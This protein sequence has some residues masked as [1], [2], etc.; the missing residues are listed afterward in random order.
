M[1]GTIRKHSKWLWVIIAALTIA[2]FVWWG[3]N[4]ASRYGSGGSGGYGTL[5]GKPITP[6]QFAAAERE[7][8][9][10]YWMRSGQ[11]P[12]PPT[13]TQL[14]IDQN[15]YQRLL[16]EAKAAELGVH[17]TDEA[18]AAE[19][20]NFLASL[21]KQSQPIAMSTFVERV[22]QPKGLTGDDFKRTLVGNLAIQ[23]LVQSIGLAGSLVPPQEVAQL[24]DHDHQEFSAQAIFF[25]ATNY[26]A[27]VAATPAAVGTFYTNHMAEY[28][29]ADRVLL[30]YVA[31]DLTNYLAATEQKLGKTNV[32]AVVEATFAQRGLEGVPDAKTPEE[33]KAKIHDAYLRQEA[34]KTAVEEARQFAKTL[35]SIE[36]ASANTLLLLAQTNGLKGQITAPFSEAEGPEEF[37]AP[38]EL[39]KTAFKLSPESPFGPRPIQGA[40]SVYV[41]ALAKQL[42][43]EVLPFGEIHDR[44][45]ADFKN[46]EAVMRA[47]EFGANFYH[48][49][50]NQ[51]TA[52]KT[53]AQAAVAAGQAPIAMKPFSLSSR[54]ILEADEHNMDA[55]EILLAAAKTQ[56][57]HLSPF[58][59][60]T[61]GAFVLFVQSVLPV[62]EAR[63]S[64]DMPQFLE[65]IRRNRL[66]EAFNRWFMVEANRELAST[67]LMKELQSQRASSSGQ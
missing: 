63:K 21:S 26:L 24:Y 37:A 59:P 19:A 46:Y 34:A 14:E 15:V 10:S 64:A 16:L 45:V 60:T 18:A 28:R 25:S 27:G 53:F 66:N 39:T 20:N 52:G 50:T 9:V 32:T 31:F 1:I 3:V 43:S 67:P 51:M 33:A 56:P 29:V 62:D 2:S 38:T 13:V 8:V 7:F 36:N 6:E 23:Q 12:Q 58:V 11:F 57:G 44:V 22:L 48:T 42:P 40:E 49:L 54:D 30:N 65:Q 61:D 55:R 47:R 4:P 41:I 17:V 5:Y 35:F